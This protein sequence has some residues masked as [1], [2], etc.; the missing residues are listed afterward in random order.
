MGLAKIPETEYCPAMSKP[1]TLEKLQSTLRAQSEKEHRELAA[2]S[3]V[4]F[5]TIRKIAYGTTSSPRYDT[6]QKL[7]AAILRQ[8]A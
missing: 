6:F 1:I 2:K 8:P 4:P 7:A 3:K 5:S